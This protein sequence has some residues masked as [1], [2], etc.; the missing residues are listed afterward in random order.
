MNTLLEI[1]TILKQMMGQNIMKLTQ[2]FHNCSF[3]V[4]INMR[5]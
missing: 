3:Y 5:C 4:A 2:N 1:S